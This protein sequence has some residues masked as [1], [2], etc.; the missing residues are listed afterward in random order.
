MRH[1]TLPPKTARRLGPSAASGRL[2]AVLTPPRLRAQPLGPAQECAD[3]RVRRPDVE[4]ST[5]EVARQPMRRF[6]WVSGLGVAGAPLVPRDVPVTE[7][8]G[9]RQRRANGV[10][11]L[12]DVAPLCVFEEPL[13]VTRA[14]VE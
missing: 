5:N 1:N 14:H 10:E 4:L 8:L 3:R 11:H 6:E 7:T 2:G 13:R 9:A 12:D